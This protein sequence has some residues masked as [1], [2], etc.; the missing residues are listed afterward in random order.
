MHLNDQQLESVHYIS[1]PCLVLAGAGSGKTRVITEKI[2]HLIQDCDYKPYNIFAVTFTN[3]AA[4]EMKERI[5]ASLSSD[6][7]KGLH[8]STFHSVGLDILRQEHIYAGLKPNFTLFDEYDQMTVIK[9]ILQELQ[10]TY[11]D[12][13]H[14]KDECMFWQNKIS[15]YKNDLVGYDEIDTDINDVNQLGAII[16]KRYE[17]TLRAINAVDFDDLIYLP[18]R[19]FLEHEAVLEKWRQRV[20]YL[21]VDEYQDTNAS[22]YQLI[23]LLVEKRQRFTVVGDDDQS[24]YSWRGARPQNISLLREDFPDLKVIMLEQNYRSCGRILKCA[25]RLIAQNE[26]DFVKQLHS[27]LEFGS[28]INVIEIPDATLEGKTIVTE[29][30]AHHYINRSKYSDYAILYRG[31][32]QSREIQK[33]LQESNIPFRVIGGT[34]FFSQA[35]I[36]DFMSYLRLIA[37]N[38]DDKAFLRIINIPKR[39]IGPTSLSYL[40]RFAKKY[41]ISLMDACNHPELI[42]EVKPKTA[43]IFKSFHDLIENIRKD[44]N[45]T[46]W[47]KHLSELPER[48]G[49]T[50]WLYQD[51]GSEKAAE[52]RLDNVRT[53]LK[54]VNNAVTGDDNGFIGDMLINDA[55][56]KLCVRELLDRN[57]EEYDLEEVQLMTLHSSKGLEFPYV[58][59]IGMEEGLLPHET[60][61]EENNVEEERRLAYVGIT[62]A[63]KELFL[64]YCKNRKSRKRQETKVEPSRFL[65]ELPEEDL[66][67]PARLK[68]TRT[69][70]EKKQT[71]DSLFEQLLNTLK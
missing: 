39:E 6:T 35:E 60:S 36:K 24:I 31:N 13:E 51:S 69:E 15:G 65:L 25:N 14:L 22:Q 11:A 61:I 71:M 7:I 67:W 5:C 18:V 56:N 54:W 38:D 8:V 48:L 28:K 50:D 27:Q 3:K 40:D 30:L 21:L 2:I 23:K 46:D 53:L 47:E 59:L 20:R 68:D 43:G 16:Y 42:N 9:E 45:G 70:E 55:I 19:M 52:I 1:G 37:N 66:H 32:Y 29:L 12:K 62:R 10:G 4:K 58:F 41:C 17:E 63:Q 64:M 34:S 57:E 33:A 44:L 26:H 49:Y